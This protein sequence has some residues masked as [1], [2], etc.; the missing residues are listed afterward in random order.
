MRNFLKHF[1]E[2]ADM[3]KNMFQLFDKDNSGSICL[4]VLLIN[5]YLL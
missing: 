1:Q 3:L 4:K 2:D 5:N